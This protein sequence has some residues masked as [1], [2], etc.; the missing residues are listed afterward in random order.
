MPGMGPRKWG[1]CNCAEPP[2]NPSCSPRSGL[3][4]SF[5]EASGEAVLTW[6]QG[7]E[8]VLWLEP[9][10]RARV[11]NQLG[12]SVTQGGYTAGIPGGIALTDGETFGP[13]RPLWNAGIMGQG[14]IVGIGDSGLDIQR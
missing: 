1:Q 3:R 10:A 8:W 12:A 2:S 6:L 11:Q 13:T 9:Q 7:Q 14:Q 4:P 5:Q